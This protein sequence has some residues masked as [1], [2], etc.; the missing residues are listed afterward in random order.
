MAGGRGSAQ[1]LA[2]QATPSQGPERSYLREGK[3]QVHSRPQLK[4]Q[5]RQCEGNGV[6]VWM[7]VRACACVRSNWGGPDM[8]DLTA[9]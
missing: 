9:C 5:E 4:L 7:C 1:A 2:F 8:H 3:K 6:D